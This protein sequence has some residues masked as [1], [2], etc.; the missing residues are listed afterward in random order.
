MI[1]T[2]RLRNWRN[3]ADVEIEFKEGVTFV[4]ATNGVGKTSMIEAARWALFGTLGPTPEAAIRVGADSA[5]ATVELILPSG[6][7]LT[8]A[9]PITRPRT[10]KDTQPGPQIAIDGTAV[11]S[12]EL[13]A[14]LT[15]EYKTDPAFLARLTMPAPNRNDDKPH[16]LGL[17]NHLG[18]LFGIDGLRSAL[19]R[20]DHLKKDNDRAIRGIK[21]T[22]SAS[23]K[24]LADLSQLVRDT[25]ASVEGLTVRLEAAQVRQE[26]VR[27]Y[28]RF[29]D[30]RASW[31]AASQARHAELEE[32]ARRTSEKTGTRTTAEAVEETIRI[33]LASLEQSLGT[34]RV[35]IA[36][37]AS[38]ADA[39][40]ANRL[41][42]DESHADCP[43]CRRPLDD[44][45]IDNAHIE[46][47]N[48]LAT[49][50]QRAAELADLETDLT[51]QRT[52]LLELQDD[53]TNMPAL[54]AEPTHPDTAAIAD[55]ERDSASLA[56]T[57]VMDALVEARA[58]V[59]QA[60]RDLEAA[61]DADQ[62]MR[63]LERL[64]R[65]EAKL[66]VAT[67]TTQ[68]TL[69]EVLETTV[70]PI[71]TEVNQRW[72]GLFPD[73]GSLTTRADGTIT[74]QVNGHDV[75][76]DSFSTGEGMGATIL[77]RLVVAHLTSVA[78]FIWFD[79]PL[80][81]LDP[82]VRRHVANMLSRITAGEG[83]VR[84]VIVTTY[85]D[86]LARQLRAR[87]SQHVHLVDVRQSHGSSAPG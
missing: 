11:A 57:E 69:D 64:F 65:R 71:A 36:V 45:T 5:E 1:K 26:R 3:Y 52:Q 77:L 44:Q 39:V 34:V 56:V 33:A 22:N 20:L 30:A 15:S 75:P 79:E 29:Q 9:R 85:E 7:V 8:I 47:D 78:D 70:S 86:P 48:E 6:R 31:V 74:R 59:T 19:S 17:E 46:A 81:H 68:A 83:S 76:F 80:E 37:A 73:R 18:R 41:R 24:R 60:K 55:D 12:A 38:Q 42:L 2:L 62:A 35:D 4:V 63:E 27:E 23:A 49:L 25:Q 50:E 61:R 21:Q 28:F 10:R 58:D 32:L 16:T 43:V 54:P 87:D 53:L 14:L 84:Q 13:P 72:S 40:A 82:D 66:R 67:E 51:D